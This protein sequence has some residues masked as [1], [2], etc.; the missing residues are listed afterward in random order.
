MFVN[1]VECKE[2]DATDY[3]RT[4]EDVRMCT[5]GRVTVMGGQEHFKFDVYTNPTYEVKKIKVEASAQELYDDWESMED[6]FGLIK[7]ETKEEPK[8]YLF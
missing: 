2:C 6:K 4:H 5:C 8:Q 1:A 7:H 3:S